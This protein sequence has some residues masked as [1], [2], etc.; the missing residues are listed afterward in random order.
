MEIGLEKK[1]DWKQEAV[2]IIQTRNDKVLRQRR[3]GRGKHY[4]RY[5]GDR[6]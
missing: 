4:W 5:L 6:I 2:K 1:A 3:L